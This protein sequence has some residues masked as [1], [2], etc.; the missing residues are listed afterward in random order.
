MILRQLQ[1]KKSTVG[2]DNGPSYAVPHAVRRRTFHLNPGYATEGVM[3]LMVP[4]PD[5]LGISLMC[6]RTKRSQLDGSVL[7]GGLTLQ[8]GWP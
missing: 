2:V 8:L 5:T 1:H 6:H 3:P 4:N 7:S